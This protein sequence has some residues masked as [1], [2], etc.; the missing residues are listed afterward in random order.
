MLA[1]AILPPIV[2]VLVLASPRE[3]AA[4]SDLA[5]QIAAVTARIEADPRRGSLYLQRGELHRA[6][7]DW[8][9]ALADY[10]RAAA[11][12]PGLPAVDLARAAVSLDADRPEAALAAIDRFLVRQPDRADGWALR[13]RIL[14]RLHR[15]LEAAED[16]DRAIRA[17]S[18]PRPEQYLERASALAAGGRIDGAVAALDEGIRRL[19]AIVTLELAAVELELAHARYDAALAR[20]DR[21]AAAAPRK[22]QWLLRRGEILEQAGR[23]AEAREAF[24]GALVAVQAL[25]EARRRTRAVGDIETRSRNALLRLEEKP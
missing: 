9:L 23:P 12:D 2:L 7:R 8:A 15:P 16:W 20:V 25:P 24:A 4:H 13:G 14:A 3:A 22:E 10:D 11:L 21:L 5:E 6:H 19:G 18:R 17:S 1:L